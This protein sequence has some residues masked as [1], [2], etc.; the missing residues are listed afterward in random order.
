M[1]CPAFIEIFSKLS[2]LHADIIYICIFA[3]AVQEPV[4]DLINQHL[5]KDKPKRNLLYTCIATFSNSY[6]LHTQTCID[7]GKCSL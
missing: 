4:S 7:S 1:L 6:M 5:N 3:F 2:D